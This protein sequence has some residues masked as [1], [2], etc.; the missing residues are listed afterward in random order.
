MLVGCAPIVYSTSIPVAVRY[1]QATGKERV[2]KTSHEV[3]KP[4][5]ASL[6]TVSASTGRS[7]EETKEIKERIDYWQKACLADWDSATHM[8]RTEWQTTCSR[9]SSER[10]AFVLRNPD[11]FSIKNTNRPR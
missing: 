4:S 5:A 10:G 2:R 1:T 7:A 6:P 3:D 11:A 8:T 9:V